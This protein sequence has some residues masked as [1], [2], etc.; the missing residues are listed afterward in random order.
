MLYI[1]HLQESTREATHRHPVQTT[2]PKKQKQADVKSWVMAATASKAIP[3]VGATDW[4]NRNPPH[5]PTAAELTIPLPR[6]PRSHL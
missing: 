3:A 5:G 4:K 6:N 1:V 2:L